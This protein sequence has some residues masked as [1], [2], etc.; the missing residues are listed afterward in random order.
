[1]MNDKANDKS[2]NDSKSKQKCSL[3]SHR[4]QLHPQSWELCLC[5]ES[6]VGLRRQ[7]GFS[8]VR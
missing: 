2:R 6:K 5:R 8:G 3:L 4:A 1:M 7:P